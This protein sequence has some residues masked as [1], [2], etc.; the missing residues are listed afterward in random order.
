MIQSCAPVTSLMIPYTLL[1]LKFSILVVFE[2]QFYGF[3]VK[4][5]FVEI[6]L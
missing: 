6:C 2:K 4:G 3:K 5:R 1:I